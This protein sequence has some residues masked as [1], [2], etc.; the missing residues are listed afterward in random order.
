[1]K[2]L[3]KKRSFGGWQHVC[4]HE[5]SILGCTMQFG[6]YIPD[7]A[8]EAKP[9]PGLWYLSGLTCTWEN[10]TTKGFP[11]AAAAKYGVAFITPDTSPR[12]DDVADDAERWDFGKGAGF[13]LN[14]TQDPWAKNYQ[15]QRYVT[16]ELQALV[17]KEFTIDASKQGITGHSMGGHGAL[18]L[19]LKFPEL[20]KS[21]SA[22]SPICHPSVVPWGE[23]AFSRYLGDDKESWKEYDATE[24]V[25]KHARPELTIL[26]DQGQADEFLER[27]LKPG[28]FAEAAQAAG[29]KVQVR[30]QE[31]YDHSYYFIASF[32]DDHVAHFANSV[33]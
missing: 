18:T 13:Y 16:E 22:F 25:K 30:M 10:V 32:M 17:C 6:V 5:S 31:G 27:E 15:M 26:I 4:E 21:I 20:Y 23:L 7:S 14:A 3:S 11:Q 1:M 12:G 24:L 2:T 28:H 29:Q 9:V 19:G 33:K 8:T